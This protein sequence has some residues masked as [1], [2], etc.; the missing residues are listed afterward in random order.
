MLVCS[1]TEYLGLRSREESR[2]MRYP[3]LTTSSI[4][5]VD[6][7]SSAR[8]LGVFEVLANHRIMRKFV[9]QRN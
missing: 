9:R 7:A 5:T 1:G 8:P 2:P 6:L 4:T 3:E